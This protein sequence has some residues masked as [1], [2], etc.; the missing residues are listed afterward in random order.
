MLTGRPLPGRSPAGGTAPSSYADDP[1]HRRPLALTALLGGA[2]AA[3][4][5]L[6]VCLALGVTGW[7]LSD[8]GAHG[9]PRDGLAVGALGWLMAHGSGVHVQGVA[10]T[11]VPLLLTFVCGW[12]CWRLGHRVGDSISGHGPDADAIAD[13]TRDWTVGIATACFALGYAAVVVVAGLLVGNREATPSGAHAVTWAVLLCLFVAGPAIAIGSGRL[14]I[15]ASFLPANVRAG[16]AAVRAM[17]LLFLTVAAITLAA[18]LVVDL[19]TAANILSELHL[20]GGE[21][22]LFM[23]VS[24]LVLPNAVGFAG[25]YLL[26]PGFVVG[27]H[28]LVTPTAVVLGPL[29]MFPL[30]AALPDQGAT[31]GWTAWL[32]G[33]PVLTAALA[34]AWTQRSR[35]VVRWSDA[36][37]RGCGGG[38]VAGIVLGFLLART[39]GA[40]GPGRMAHIGP[41]AL[42]AMVHAVTAFGIG[43]A[44]GALAMTWW[45]RR[46]YPEAL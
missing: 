41:F 43:G 7:F 32:M 20:S 44:L 28:T 46:R 37:I 14:A 3:G 5:V 8:A 29:P 21:A 17:V 25:S 16:A 42:D 9:A 40:V 36:L 18:A 24:A 27:T 38:V 35:P 30:L 6:T 34:A 23:V 11:A 2:A 45:Q 4:S 33:L 12:V 19:T 26:G 1:R 31:P 10:V 13:G 39:G 15:W 22:V